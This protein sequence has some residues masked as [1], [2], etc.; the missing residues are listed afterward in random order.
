MRRA[1][2]RI[3]SVFSLVLLTMIGFAGLANSDAQTLQ[4]EPT[5]RERLVAGLQVRR[6][7][8]FAYIDAVVDTVERGELPQKVV[9]RYFFWAREKPARSV[10]TQRPIIYF[11]QGLTRAAL[12]MKITIAPTPPPSTS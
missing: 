3:T 4:K 10:A 1:H 8:E 11:E 7:S 2:L 5:L 6:P 12:K 9:D